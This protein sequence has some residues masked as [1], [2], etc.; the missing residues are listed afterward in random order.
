[1]KNLSRQFGNVL[2]T[3]HIGVSDHE[4]GRNCVVRVGSTG[5]L[6]ELE[7]STVNLNIVVLN[8]TVVRNS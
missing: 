2:V 8:L 6:G 4:A 5:L 3:I 7:V 1:M